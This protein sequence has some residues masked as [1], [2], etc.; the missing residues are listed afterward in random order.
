MKK[1]IFSL[2]IAALAL[3]FAG[4]ACEKDVETVLNKEFSTETDI[5]EYLP[6]ITYGAVKLGTFNLLYGAYKDNEQYA[7]ATRKG[8]LAQAIAEN[9]FDVFGVQEADQTI[10][11]QLPD[12]VKTAVTTAKTTRNYEWWFVCRDNQA[13]TTGEAIGIVYDANKFTISDQHYFWLSPTPDVL[14][15]G[16]D[17]TGYHRM[18][19]CAVLTEKADTEKK[20]FL[21]VTHAP[22]AATARLNSATLIC[23]KAA[24]YNANKLPAFI[25][26]DM[27][28]APDDPSTGV[29]K[30]SSEPYKWN[31]SYEKVPATAKVGGV[32]TFHSKKD[33]SDITAAE[34][35]IDYIYYKNLSKV[36]TYKVDYNKYNGYY[37]SDHCAVSVTFDIP[38]S[39]PPAP[40]TPSDIKGTGTPADPYQIASVAD[41]NTVVASINTGGSYA[42]NACYMLTADLQFAGDFTRI[43]TFSG[44]LEGANHSMKGISGEAAEE[45]FGGVI[46]ILDDGGTVKN[47]HVE[48]N[49]SSAFAHLG[50][51]V[52]AANAGSLIDGVTFRGDLTGTGAA[53][54]IGGIVGTGYG[55]IVNCGC[56]G[57]NFEA[58]SA[59]KSENIGGIAGRIEQN[60]AM[61]FNCYSFLDKIVSSNNNLG[62]VTGGLGTNSYCANVYATTTSITGGG[63][64]GGCIGYSKSG[65]IR[66]VYAPEEAAFAGASTKWVANDKEASDWL[67]TGTSLTLANMKSGAV[68]V[69]SSGASC[70]SFVAALN[71]GVEDWKALANV[72]ALQGKDVKPYGIVNKPDVTLRAWVVDVNTGYPVVSAD[73][74]I[75]PAPDP[76]TEGP[77]GDPIVVDIVFKDYAAENNWIIGTDTNPLTEVYTT[78]QKNG[79]TLTAG[80]NEGQQNGVYNSPSYYDWRFYQARGGKITISVPDGHQ[81]QAVTFDYYEYKNGGLMLDPDGNQCLDETEVAVSGQ[82]ATFVVGNQGSAT[83]GQ[84]RILGIKVKYVKWGTSSDPGTGGGGGDSGEATK[85]SVNFDEY[86]PDKG[87]ENGKN[88]ETVTTGDVTITASWVGDNPNGVYYVG[89]APTR[90]DW[91]FYQARQGGI[92]LA[93]PSG[94]QLVKVTFT[95]TNKNGGVIIAPDGEATVASGDAFSLTGQSAT[96]TVSSPSA[97]NGQARINEIEIEYK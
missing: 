47:L 23:Q 40:P 41:W 85:V 87:W 13:A 10:R 51:V 74:N 26:G 48:A 55:V 97:T 24:E 5:S 94:K 49:L 35:R 34:N 29:Y 20:F 64:Y 6:T 37:P 44:V 2:V 45:K 57:G 25:V 56:L 79:V 82:E 86:G 52:G 68:T 30:G 14:S 31:D 76:G 27:N 32:I 93:V 77:I 42:A 67:T 39:T 46:N 89:T 60:T 21:M 72:A 65:N 3:L 78:V 1:N 11:N 28:A 61:M 12:L 90:N 70:E 84:A 15:K 83:N 62:G 92:T 4:T 80:G 96:F 19:C 9:D 91:R 71:A 95:Y 88:Y 69:P 81:L 53:A 66:N 38:A 54:R 22:L 75:G 18:A 73:A 17:E 8:V 16:W 43:T 63:T 59:T 58:G 7:W 36:L 50:G 33:I